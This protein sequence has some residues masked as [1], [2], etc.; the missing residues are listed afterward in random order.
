MRG[1]AVPKPHY[2]ARAFDV[3]VTPPWPSRRGL[4]PPLFC[5]TTRVK[6][7]TF[8]LLLSQLVYL[9]NYLLTYL[10]VSSA[11]TKSHS[12]CTQSTP[13]RLYANIHQYTPQY[14]PICRS[15]RL[16][17]Q[18]LRVVA[19]FPHMLIWVACRALPM[20]RLGL[21]SY[22]PRSA[23]MPGRVAGTTTTRYLLGSW[24]PPP[25]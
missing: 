19:S 18:V 9:L 5:S 11:C 21:C 16:T 22:P 12:I 25:M 1:W 14:T 23:A 8:P 13:E 3:P 6:N 20:T 24:D 2:S 17:K 7:D 4:K 15:G 10:L